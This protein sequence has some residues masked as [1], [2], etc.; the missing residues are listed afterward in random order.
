MKE[1]D[2]K[3]EVLRERATRLSRPAEEAP[4]DLT[5]VIVFRLGEELYGMEVVHVVEI[6]RPERITIIPGAPQYIRGVTNLRGKIVT[7]IDLKSL[8]IGEQVEDAIN[9]A[10]II[11]TATARDSAGLLVDAVT[12]IYDIR[13]AII[14]PPLDT[15][16]KLEADHLVGEFRLEKELV[17][18]LN[19]T[20][21]LGS[22]E[23]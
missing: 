6:F 22:V 20:N 19:A 21:I 13:A 17:G 16:E 14:D 3:R 12:G 18:L 8:L 7:V 10:R 5:R 2:D 9:H 23:I 1:T 4:T 15:L 11:V